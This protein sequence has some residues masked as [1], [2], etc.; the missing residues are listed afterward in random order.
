MPRCLLSAG[1]RPSN[2]SRREEG[3]IKILSAELQ[4]RPVGPRL[5]RLGHRVELELELELELDV[6]LDVDVD[7]DVEVEVEVEVE[8]TILQ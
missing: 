1:M 2:L 6:E 7:V 3:G 4:H 8:V 5:D